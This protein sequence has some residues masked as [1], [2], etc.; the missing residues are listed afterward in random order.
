MLSRLTL[1][2]QR[3]RILYCGGYFLGDLSRN[4]CLWIQVMSF[5][6]ARGRENDV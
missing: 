6:L 3:Q 5:I 2:K 1:S 4:L